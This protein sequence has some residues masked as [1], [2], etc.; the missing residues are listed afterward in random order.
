MV[1]MTKSVKLEQIAQW[2]LL[3]PIPTKLEHKQY[4]THYVMQFS[5][6]ENGSYGSDKQAVKLKS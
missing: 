3:K 1:N 6:Y 2:Y 4:Q 5:Y